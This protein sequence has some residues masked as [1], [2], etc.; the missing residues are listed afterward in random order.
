MKVIVNEIGYTIW[1]DEGS[2]VVVV[3]S[4]PVPGGNF[5]FAFIQVIYQEIFV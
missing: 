2:V 4:Y 1:P 5:M 3:G